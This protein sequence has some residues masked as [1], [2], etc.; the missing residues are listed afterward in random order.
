MRTE[1]ASIPSTNTDRISGFVAGAKAMLAE[2]PNPSGNDPM[3]IDVEF[4]R[5]GNCHIYL[6]TGR[7][8]GPYEA[9][10]SNCEPA[11]EVK[12]DQK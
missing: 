9:D 7:W 1:L 3:D 5:S 2:M 10:F 12:Y 6:L 4:R 11:D 8:V